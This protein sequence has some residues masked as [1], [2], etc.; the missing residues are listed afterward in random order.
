MDR[1]DISMFKQQ[2]YAEIKRLEA[3]S[4]A[5]EVAG[6]AI[7]K[8]G[9]GYITLIIV[10]G[11]GASLFLDN[12]KIAA[13]M[14]LLGAALT[15]LISMLNGIAGAQPKQEKPEFEVI[16]HLIDKLDKLDRDELPMRV[17]VEGDKVT[18]RKGEDIVTA[19][20]K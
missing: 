4:T 1:K 18:V 2:V 9:L 10:I 12:D 8:N 16:K 7:G 17:D 5:K 19:R 6:K 20:S 14:G 13:V 15:A 11:V 3:Q